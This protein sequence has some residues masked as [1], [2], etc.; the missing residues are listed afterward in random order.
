MAPLAPCDFGV[1]RTAA[2]GSLGSGRKMQ[3]NLMLPVREL[4][5]P[6]GANHR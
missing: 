3:F 4:L 2:A 6:A 1:L 5:A